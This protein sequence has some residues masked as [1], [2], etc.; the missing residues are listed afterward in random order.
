MNNLVEVSGVQ[1]KIGAHEI[2]HDLSL[3]IGCGKLVALLGENGAGKTTLMRILSGVAKNY[4]GSVSIDG[5][6]IGPATKAKV[7]YLSDL[8]DFTK[9]TKL[10]QI[11]RFYQD[12]YADFDSERAT[13]L[14]GFMGL[15]DQVRLQSLST[16]N[17][18]KFM[19]VL[20]LARRASLYLLDEP[21]SGVDILARER[22]I[23]A[24]IEFFSD[25]ATI[26]ISTHHIGEMEQVVDDVVI[27]KN[28]EII[29]HA[30]ADD[31]RETSGQG[32]EEYYRTAYTQGGQR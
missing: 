30:P 22:I 18:Q 15:D 27:M 23:K 26:F 12:V 21:L 7:S 6:A 25:D 3:E 5:Q 4:R 11:I 28:Q 9:D 8:S 32:L 16:G 24:M 17:V 31:I 14:M 29:V 1:Y 2:F 20:T 13:Q 10:Q 19:M